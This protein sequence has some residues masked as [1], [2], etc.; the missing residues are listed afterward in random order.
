MSKKNIWTIVIVVLIFDALTLP[1]I[2]Y[3]VMNRDKIAG[4]AAIT[5]RA[6]DT[7]PAMYAVP[8]FNFT[9]QDGAAFGKAQLDGKIW[10]ADVFFT[11]CAG[12]C[13]VMTNNL[14]EIAKLYEPAAGVR[15]VSFTVDPGTDTPEVLSAY[16][17][18][19]SADPAEWKFLTGDSAKLQDFASKGLKL[20]SGDSPLIHSE[21]FVLVDRKGMVR[22]YFTG[23]DPG[24]MTELKAAIDVLLKEA[25]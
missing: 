5:S 1:F 23:T 8:D 13:P 18:R 2:I 12:P 3:Y 25:A 11:S 24:E 14:S 20:G 9:A 16:A 7:L 21:Y 22:G 19:Y 10:I 6:A 15:F 4:E 17:Q